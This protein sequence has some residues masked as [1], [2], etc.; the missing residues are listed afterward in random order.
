[1]ER[2]DRVVVMGD[3][4][5]GSGTGWGEVVEDVVGAR[6]NV[7]LSHGTVMGTIRGS[8]GLVIS[9]QRSGMGVER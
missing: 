2:T 5:K 9:G 3:G 7:L 6:A 4:E 8:V 1:M